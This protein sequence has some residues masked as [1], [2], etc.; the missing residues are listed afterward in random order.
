M[1]RSWIYAMTSVILLFFHS[2]IG[3]H[4]NSTTFKLHDFLYFT[5]L[6][7]YFCTSS[8]V[9]TTYVRLLWYTFLQTCS[10]F[11][12]EII[13]KYGRRPI[14]STFFVTISHLNK[15]MKQCRLWTC[16]S[17]FR[18]TLPS[19]FWTYLNLC[20]G[21]TAYLGSSPLSISFWSYT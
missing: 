21:S 20:P 4:S 11:S 1:N 19:F 14:V 9:F 5:V 7:K 13:M 12:L 18:T 8:G 3:F 16:N 17:G 2:L 10:V 15:C 6:L